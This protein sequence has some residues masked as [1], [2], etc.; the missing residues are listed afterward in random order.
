MGPQELPVAQLIQP[1]NADA[2]LVRSDMFGDDVQRNFAEVEVGTDR[3]GGSDPS[4]VKHIFDYT[5]LQTPTVQVRWAEDR[6]RCP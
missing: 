1:R 3:C 4:G 5:L 2:V 6:A